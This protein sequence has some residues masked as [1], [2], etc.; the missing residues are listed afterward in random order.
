MNIEAPVK[1]SLV[2]CFN[3]KR[4]VGRK[5]KVFKITIPLAPGLKLSHMSIFVGT[6]IESLFNI[7]YARTASIQ[8]NYSG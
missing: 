5:L 1:V 2:R 6:S 4:G 3:M 8:Y 7:Y